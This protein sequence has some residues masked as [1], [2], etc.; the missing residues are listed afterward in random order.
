MMKEENNFFS[1]KDSYVKDVREDIEVNEA[2]ENEEYRELSE[3][4]KIKL[5]WFQD[6]KLGVIFHW[7]LYALA[8]IVE[9]WQLSEEDDWART[10]GWRNSVEEIRADYWG[11]NHF[12]NPYQFHPDEWAKT[13][14]DA[15]IRYMIFTTKHHDGF[16][17]YDTKYSEYKVTAAPCPYANQTNPDIFA[18][19]SEAFRKEGLSVGAYYSK[20]DWH[21]PLYWV[22]EEHAKGRLASYEPAEFPERWDQYNQ[23]VTNQLTEISKNYGAIDILWLDGG[24]VNARNEQLDMDTIAQ[25][26]RAS[27]P[28]MLIVD[29][30]IGGTYENYVTPERK[31]PDVPP[32][33]VWESNIPLANN[34]GFSPNDQYKSFDEIL[35]SFVQVVALGGNLILGVGPKPNGELPVEA[36]DILQ[37]LGEWLA[38]FGEAIYETRAIPEVTQQGWL[39][40]KK[41]QV[42]YAFQEKETTP[43]DLRKLNQ[44]IESIY[45]L[46]T[47]KIVT[48]TTLNPL[49]TDE[50]YQVYKI[51]LKKESEENA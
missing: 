2:S 24:W 47:K 7:G 10:P 44:P 51:C 8:G 36:V 39:F 12:F 27:Q 6:Q 17:M 30:T 34:W 38:H 14:K 1:K 18:E 46:N 11:L 45:H 43:L 21:S 42:I 41:E 5:D 15:G 50:A 13:C 48:E 4:L 31:I 23:F 20:P 9:S 22:P 33:K 3:N 40:T 19:V 49:F 35:K 16:T 37:K 29:R 28:D 26:V 32:K 25:Q